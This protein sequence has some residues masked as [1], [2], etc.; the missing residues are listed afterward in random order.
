MPDVDAA[1]TYLASLSDEDSAAQ[2]YTA[3]VTAA[4]CAFDDGTAG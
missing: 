2:Q 1:I 3:T 4:Q